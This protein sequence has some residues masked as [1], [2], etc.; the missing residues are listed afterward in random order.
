MGAER[1]QERPDGVDHLHRVR[2]GLALDRQDDGPRVGA[3]AGDLVVLHAIDDTTE[4]FQAHRGTVA[5]RD[6]QRTV[7]SGIVELAA[8]FDGIRLVAS[9]QVACWEVDVPLRDG[10]LDLV[11]PDPARREGGR[12]D[13]DPHRILLRSEDLYLRNAAHHGDALGQE[14]LR[15]L[16]HGRQR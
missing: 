11:D 3:P 14:G 6:D 5:E 1:G 2:A 9:V 13:L 7:G 4:L 16:I 8:C 15:M 10:V 12:I